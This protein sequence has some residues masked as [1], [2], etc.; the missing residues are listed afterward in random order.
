MCRGAAGAA[1][2]RHEPGPSQA[3]L[4]GEKYHPG[5]G[6]PFAAEGGYKKLAARRGGHS[7]T[8]RAFCAYSKKI[9]RFNRRI[10]RRSACE[11][12]RGPLVLQL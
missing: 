2:F 8:R 5:K 4:K 12:P 1:A 9:P 10:S 7:A 6:R 3:A 11:K